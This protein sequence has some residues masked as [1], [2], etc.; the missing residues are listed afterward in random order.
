MAD[1]KIS[2]LSDGSPAQSSDQIPV[3]RSG[4]NYRVNASSMMGL[5]VLETIALS[6]DASIE[7]TLPGGYG[8]YALR[9]DGVTMS[10]SGTSH[11]VGIQYKIAAA[12]VTTGYSN[13]VGNETDKGVLA[14]DFAITDF[15]SGLV[16]IHSVGT[17]A[18][19]T[20]HSGLAWRSST[21]APAPPTAANIQSLLANAGSVTDIKV[22]PDSGTLDAGNISLLGVVAS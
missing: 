15:M 10:G 6:S 21:G 7:F 12:Y 5:P 20:T 11:A 9:F 18:F 3:N 19:K 13:N 8:V 1:T 22:L 14:R 16:Y 2:A 4:T 17:Q